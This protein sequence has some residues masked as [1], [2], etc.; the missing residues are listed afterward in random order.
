MFG[1][2]RHEFQV[3]LATMLRETL[4]QV[5]EKQ[6]EKQASAAMSLGETKATMEKLQQE[7]SEAEAEVE[8]AKVIVEEKA[9]VL[10][11]KQRVAASEA[12]RH[13]ETLE[14]NDFVAKYHAELEESKNGIDS[15]VN[16]SLSMLVGGSWDSDSLEDY[17][18]PVMDYLQ[19][20]GCDK[21]LLAALPKALGCSPEKRG[22]FAKLSVDEAVKRLNEKV[23][24]ITKSLEES[25]VKFEEANAENLGAWA[26]AEV[27]RDAEN[28]ALEA[29][30]TAE[31]HLAKATVDDKLAFSKVDD[32]KMDV[33]R[34]LAEQALIET[35]ISNIDAAVG[36]MDKLETEVVE[37]TAESI[38]TNK[39]NIDVA[40]P[41]AKRIKLSEAQ[42]SPAVQ[43]ETESAVAVQ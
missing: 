27:A 24:S 36:E 35:K 14:G 26:I 33:E 11:E 22:D 37:P 25:K 15:I 34:I 41:A 23:A 9:A 30:M 7:K 32:I 19:N 12:Q 31:N 1:S 21:V 13:K 38:E 42:S 5:G 39:E 43:G 10:T 18:K 40:S 6:T 17:L 2:D 4:K 28:A 29:N 20:M 3:R 8:K 16:G